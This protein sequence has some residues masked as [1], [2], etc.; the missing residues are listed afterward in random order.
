MYVAE[1]VCVK[2]TT[3]TYVYRNVSI[4]RS[5]LETKGKGDN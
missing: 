2:Y 4:L 5:R 3:L 1:G